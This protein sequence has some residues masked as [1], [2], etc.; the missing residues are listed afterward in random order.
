SGGRLVA[1]RKY[2][3]VERLVAHR[4][5]PDGKAEHVARPARA[6]VLVRSHREGIVLGRWELGKI[7]PPQDHKLLSV[8]RR[9][10]QVAGNFSFEERLDFRELPGSVAKAVARGKVGL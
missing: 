5:D 2:R 6:L 4:N 1:R 3:L 7:N 10:Q 8:P 9:N